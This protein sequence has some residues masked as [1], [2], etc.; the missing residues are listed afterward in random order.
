MKLLKLAD[1]SRIFGFSRTSIYEQIRD[2]VFT[3]P[4]K[5]G[6]K[7]SRW[8]DFEVEQIIKARISGK[9]TKQIRALITSLHA[10]RDS[11]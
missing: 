1:V 6:P 7:T 8:P 2:G 11:L 3:K 5:V 4:I 10:S 9:T